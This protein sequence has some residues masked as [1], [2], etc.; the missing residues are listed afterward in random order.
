MN[1]K[2][3]IVLVVAKAPASG[4]AKTR[5][6][7]GIGMD[8]A[9]N[10]YHSF[11]RDAIGIARRVRETTPGVAYTPAGSEVFFDSV[12]TGFERVLQSGPDLGARL[13]NAMLTCF[14]RGYAQVAVLSSDAPLVD[15]ADVAAGF[16]ALDTGADVALGPCDDGGYY[17]MALRAPHAELLVPIQMSTPAVLSDTLAAARQANLRVEMLPATLDIDVVEDLARLRLALERLPAEFA[18]NTRLWLQNNPSPL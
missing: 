8:A 16:A 7:A 11:L 17:L 18:P 14:E 2:A 9:A 6:G 15:P 12:A 1:Q 5:L 4:Q 13:H 3:R 10:L